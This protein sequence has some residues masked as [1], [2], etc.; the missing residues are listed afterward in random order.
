M[1]SFGSKTE[2][3]TKYASLQSF[4][5]YL[6][7]MLKVLNPTLGAPLLTGTYNRT[8]PSGSA[9]QLDWSV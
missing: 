8:F 3:L 4:A 2:H 9:L 7:N 5:I 6:A 1:D